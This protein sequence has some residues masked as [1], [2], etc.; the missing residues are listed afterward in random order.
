MRRTQIDVERRSGRS[1]LDLSPRRRYRS[2][3]AHLA[4]PAM[5]ISKKHRRSISVDGTKYLWWVSEDIEDDFIGSRVLTV[6][7][8]DRRLL[9]R[10]GLS[11]PAPGRYMIVLGPRLQGLSD[12]PGPC[13][14][15]ACP[16]FGVPGGVTP[17]HVAELIRWC[18]DPAS[19][20]TEVDYRGY[21]VVGPT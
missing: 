4:A 21:P 12:R 6:A 3:T 17:K 1:L 8:T 16:G 7:S 11:Q 14:R 10:Y 9:V 5:A 13:R 15:Y 19:S 2:R 20:S 18:V